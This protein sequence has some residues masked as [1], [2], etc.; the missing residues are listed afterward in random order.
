MKKTKD[1]HMEVSEELVEPWWE[2]R[3]KMRN[4]ITGWIHSEEGHEKYLYNEEVKR[5]RKRNK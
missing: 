1:M 3:R 5:Q 4:P 2:G